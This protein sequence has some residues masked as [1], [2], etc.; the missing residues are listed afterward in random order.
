MPEL[1]VIIA[2]RNRARQLG[3]ALAS[4]QV[5]SLPTHSFEIVV[6]DNG[7]SD[8]TAELAPTA[9]RPF[10]HATF[11]QEPK[12]GAA[13]ARNAGVAASTTGVVVFLDDDIVADA[14]LLAE[15]VKSHADGANIAVLG[16]VR[17]PWQG[18]ESP[19]FRLLVQRPE[20]LQS[21]SFADPQ[22]VSFLHFYTCN[23]SMRRAFFQ[24]N[25]GFDERFTGSGFEDT[26]LGYRFLQAGGRMIFNPRASA[27]HHPEISAS[28]LA[29]KQFNNGRYLAYLL[30]KHS[31]LRQTFV[32][33]NGEWRR[34]ISAAVGWT[35]SP[36][37]FAFDNPC[38]QP[39]SSLLARLCWHYVQR[40]YFRGLAIAESPGARLQDQR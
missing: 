10:R 2:T 16:A 40:E 35:V 36:L 12:P 32:P 9:L 18:T 23:L 30:H 27:L 15:H 39:L 29:R 11:L 17:F 14:E 8:N 28:V 33:D 5:Q 19:L 3:R 7:S 38:P 37:R 20:L 31:Q 24:T 1:S 13:A 25:A 6:V 22:D 34:R 4:L 26:E 21:F